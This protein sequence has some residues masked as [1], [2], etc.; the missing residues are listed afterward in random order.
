MELDGEIKSEEELDVYQAFLAEVVI[1]AE[2]SID[3]T[4]GPHVEAWRKL[5]READKNIREINI[6]K[7]R[8][9]KPVKEARQ[10]LEGAITRYLTKRETE[11]QAVL[12]SKT[13]NAD[14]KYLAEELEKASRGESQFE[15]DEVLDLLDEARDTE[16]VEGDSKTVFSNPVGTESLT[17]RRLKRWELIDEEEVNPEFWVI[18]KKKINAIVQK[19]FKKAEEIVGGIRVYHELSFSQKRSFS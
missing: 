9:I 3:E 16:E 10:K 14:V 13:S 1:T 17:G 5:K 11:K 12:S 2:K 7:G 6:S 15:I 18:D 8:W 19:K 4:F